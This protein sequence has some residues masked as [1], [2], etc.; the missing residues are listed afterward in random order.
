MKNSDLFAV[1]NIAPENG[2][3][4]PGG[5]ILGNIGANPDT[6]PAVFNQI[7][8]TIIGVMSIVG[9]I[10]FIFLFITGAIGF[11]TAGG[12]KTKAEEAKKR[13]TYGVVGIIVVVFA[14]FFVDLIGR[15]LGF[16]S[17]LNPA[18]FLESLDSTP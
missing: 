18:A 2:F 3:G 5:G 12:D 8:S 13:I 16:E 1:I 6:A 4:F 11:M 14:I 15:L 7:I 9:G 17:I 10:W